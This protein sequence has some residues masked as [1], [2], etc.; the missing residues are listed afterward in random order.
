MNDEGRLA[1]YQ[2][3]LKIILMSIER[4]K[5]TKN[6]RAGEDIGNKAKQYIRCCEARAFF[7]YIS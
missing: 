3:A 1:M 2:I 7:P 4:K 5:Q 6:V